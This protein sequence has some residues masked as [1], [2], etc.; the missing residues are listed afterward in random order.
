MHHQYAPTPAIIYAE[1]KFV[2]TKYIQIT[3]CMFI[4][5]AIITGTNNNILDTDNNKSTY[6]NCQYE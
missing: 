5:P 2:H 6:Y 4:S 3:F 1:I